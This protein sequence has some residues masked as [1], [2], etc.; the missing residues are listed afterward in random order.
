MARRQPGQRARL[1]H[2]GCGCKRLVALGSGFALFNL[3]VGLGFVHFLL[4]LALGFFL[5][6][7]VLGLG[8]GILLALLHVWVVGLARAVDSR[9]VHC[10]RLRQRSAGAAGR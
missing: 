9:G 10:V 2:S 7:L 5:A 6:R 3:H 8:I 4:G 1:L